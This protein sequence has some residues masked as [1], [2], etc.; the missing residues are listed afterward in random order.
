MAPSSAKGYG[1]L[2]QYTNCRILRDG[3]IFIEDLWV[4]DGKI[5]NP[6]VLFFVEK[7]NADQRIDC[8][9]M[10]IAPGFIDLQINGKP[11]S[12][13]FL[14]TLIPTGGCGYDFSTE[15][16]V[17]E[18]L[19]KVSHGVL[20]HGVTSFC[21]TVITSPSSVYK[22]IL[23]KIKKKNGSKEGA[24][25]LGVHIEGP[26]IDREKRGAH[27][28]KYIKDYDNGFSDVLEVYGDLSNVAMI[29]LAP[30][31]KKTVEVIQEFCK[32][33]IAVSVGHSNANLSQG[34]EAVRAGAKFITHLFN[35]M[36]PF[37]HRDPH[38]V[39]LLTSD[40]FPQNRKVYYGLISDGIH[41]H[42]AALRIA[43]R[44]HP[45]GIVLV[46]DAIQATFLP[47][48]TYPFGEQTVVVKGKYSYLK[49]TNTLAG[50]TASLDECVR[51]FA[52]E[53]GCGH[54]LALEAASLHPAQMLD[55]VD[56]KGTL[57]FGSD[58]DF[59]MLDDDLQVRATF[60]AGEC[61]YRAQ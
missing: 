56:K 28:E 11:D 60:I 47:D 19:K 34:E 30:E 4:R 18:G 21:P 49:D 3:K 55:I 22:Q 8:S 44:V 25:V 6:E 50:S 51:L 14:F 61:V 52:K 20:A 10:I 57:D 2:Y 46:T 35:A 29:T 32:R 27:P 54:A 5:M 38:L 59:I 23:P 48:G 42:P 13:L 53:T 1:H 12:N 41:T 40:K 9:N 43:H 26:F 37:H 33:G 16:Q 15:S 31:K 17:E 45:E 24:G 36:L 58:A 39:G 7:V